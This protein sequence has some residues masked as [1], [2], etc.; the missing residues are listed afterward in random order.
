[1]CIRLLVRLLG[2]GVGTDT[3]LA[4]LVQDGVCV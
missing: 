4:A 1:M 3:Y 2:S